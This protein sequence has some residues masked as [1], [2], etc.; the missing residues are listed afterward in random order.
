MTYDA[1]S[2]IMSRGVVKALSGLD[3]EIYNTDCD[4][5]C[6]IVRNVLP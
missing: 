2:I 6:C 3:Y 1:L 5:I 4:C